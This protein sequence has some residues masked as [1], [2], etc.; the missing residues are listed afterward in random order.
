MKKRFTS[1][2]NVSI[3][4]IAKDLGV[5]PGTIS[6]A[7][8]NKPEI[9][10]KMRTM[11]AERAASLGFKLRKFEPRTTNIGALIETRPDSNAIFSHY[12][13]EVLNGMWDYC[14]EN[15]LELSIYADEA[16]HLG[17]G[18]LLRILGRRGVSG[19]VV[20]NGSQSSSYFKAF[21]Q[22][23]FPYCCSMTGPNEAQPWIIQS[24]S[25][26]LSYQAAE[27]LI[28]L[29]HRKIAYLDSLSGF[30]IGADRRKGFLRA[31][32]DFSVPVDSSLIIDN[33]SIAT[34]VID[35]FEFASEAVERL[36]SQPVHPTA[37]IGMSSEAG[38][39]IINKL[40][41]KGIDVPKKISVISFDDARHCS[42][43]TPKLSVLRIPYRQIGHNAA[44]VV[45]RRILEGPGF[46]SSS[47][48]KTTGELVV[49][50]STSRVCG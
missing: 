6:R 49:R 5:N 23:K 34:K 11:V 26:E 25:E 13:H 38:I 8:R 35:D 7:L 4:S 20:I 16:E 30:E 42:F 18:D 43:V 48:P 37:I 12:V 39:S 19:S 44:M 9:S 50:E 32:K 47:A 46:T 15:D 1:K 10:T 31:C 3:Y 40:R 24:N 29:G 41:I 27:H 33:N 45:H 28:Q 21:N 22:Q 14:E 36:L 17:Q 2:E